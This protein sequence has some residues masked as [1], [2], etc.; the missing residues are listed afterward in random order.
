M[1]P[2]VSKQRQHFGGIQLQFHFEIL[3]VWVISETLQVDH[4][5]RKVQITKHLPSCEHHSQCYFSEGWRLKK[6]STNPLGAKRLHHKACV[7]NKNIV[8]VIS[9]LINL[10]VYKPTLDLKGWSGCSRCKRG[11]HQPAWHSLWAALPRPQPG[12]SPS[13]SSWVTHQ[14]EPAPLWKGILS[15]QATPNY[16]IISARVGKIQIE[17]WIPGRGLFKFEE[18][19]DVMALFFLVIGINA[20]DISN[21]HLMISW[22]RKA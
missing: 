16:K 18:T 14:L 1:F 10:C 5:P 6:W 3:S 19:A 21:E 15:F 7:I 12:Y 11:L 20:N 22:C 2:R 4:L 17:K 13:V 9:Y 8:V